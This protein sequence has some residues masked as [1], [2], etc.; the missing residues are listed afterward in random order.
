[1]IQNNSLG[2]RLNAFKNNPDLKIEEN[3]PNSVLA[4]FIGN[5]VSLLVITS[6]TVVFGYSCKI[7]FNTHWNF[8]EVVC[9]GIAINFVMAYIHN[10]IHE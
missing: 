10:L 4:T 8:W 3:I 5:V 2:D 1:M 9:I 6:K 7:I